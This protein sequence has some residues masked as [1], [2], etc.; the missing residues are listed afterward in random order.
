MPELDSLALWREKKAAVFSSRALLNL[1][2]GARGSEQP[3]Q[4]RMQQVL[5]T[6]EMLET[7]HRRFV[8]LRLA[9]TSIFCVTPFPPLFSTEPCDATL[10]R[11]CHPP[12]REGIP[13]G[14]GGGHFHPSP[15]L[16]D[17]PIAML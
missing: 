17:P 13:S 3:L 1:T 10:W 4:N 14:A 5:V 2:W 7:E 12:P 16:Y 6:W 15:P 9:K 11:S 8:W